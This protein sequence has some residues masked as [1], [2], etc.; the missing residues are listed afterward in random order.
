MRW[1]DECTRK[2][3][4]QRLGIKPNAVDQL[5][6]NA[7]RNI[8]AALRNRFPNIGDSDPRSWR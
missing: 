7:R 2:E 8:L 6:T 4:A 5:L 1:V 3:I